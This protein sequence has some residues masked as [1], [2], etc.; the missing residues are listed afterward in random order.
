MDR[1]DESRTINLF[2]QLSGYLDP[3]V[4]SLS[5]PD[6]SVLLR[7]LGSSDTPS[8]RWIIELGLSASGFNRFRQR[9]RS[10]QLESLLR[11]TNL[12]LPGPL[13]PALSTTVALQDDPRDL[14]PYQRAA[15]LIFGAYSLYHSLRLA[16]LKPDQF[17]DHASEMGLYPNLFSTSLIVDHKT[18]RLF[19]GVFEP[20]ITLLIRGH[21][22]LLLL[23]DL[24]TET[25]VES[26]AAAIEKLAVQVAPLT[27]NEM[28]PG[29]LTAAD[30][31]T[32]Q[33]IFA[34]LAHDPIDAP[35]LRR[36]RRSYL[37]V[38]L[39]LES[40]PDS[41][42]E[43]ARLTHSTNFINRWFHASCQIIV[44]GNSRACTNM[45]YHAY[46]DGEVML[47]SAAEIQQRAVVYPIQFDEPEA[48]GV[49]YKIFEVDWDIQPKAVP[50]VE[51]QRVQDEINALVDQQ[52]ATFEL[53]GFGH[54]FFDNH[55]INS[56]AGFILAL[57]AALGELTDTPHSVDRRISLAGYRCMDE[58]LIKLMTDEGQQYLDA[59]SRTGNPNFDSNEMHDRLIAAQSAHL[60][61]LSQA[62]EKMPPELL[63]QL[64]IKSRNRSQRIR[65]QAALKVSFLSMKISRLD[66]YYP[67][68]DVLV[69]SPRVYPQAPVV[70][71]PGLR[72]PIVKS[73]GMYYQIWPDRIVM[74]ISPGVHWKIPNQVLVEQIEKVIVGYS[75]YKT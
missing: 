51:Y 24:K 18:P 8:N 5:D 39:D 23:G 68:P 61:C 57:L 54:T 37:T 69:S 62:Q 74:T 38:C 73:L 64:F 10:D 60:K 59:L 13:S 34:Q 15:T 7:R 55:G 52:P 70:G 6:L 19:K 58:V 9:L 48:A 53:P 49:E 42:E 3:P 40:F 45:N 4:I 26:L 12:R 47:R 30:T 32:Q 17:Q 14:S 25:W 1:P 31:R 28:S 27:S 50:P 56:D 11:S 72:L 75:T 22:Y 41:L 33:R 63:I 66:H 21:L 16:E 44:F 43:A 2:E 20:Q 65:A 46:L 36:M 35:I 67:Q 71:R 29:I